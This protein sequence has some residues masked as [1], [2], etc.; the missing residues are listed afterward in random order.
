MLSF[1]LKIIVAC[2]S[3]YYTAAFSLSVF[4]KLT[5]F[6]FWKLQNSQNLIFPMKKEA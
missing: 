5:P 1:F 6:K 3:S 4:K 2:R